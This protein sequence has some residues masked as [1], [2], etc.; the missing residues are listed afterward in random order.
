MR[1]RGEQH[2]YVGGDVA[3]IVEEKLGQVREGIALLCISSNSLYQR[4][5]K[6]M[7]MLLFRIYWQTSMS[8]FFY[9]FVN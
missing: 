4:M 8:H 9:F 3:A 6:I 1:L 7:Q 2:I 5:R